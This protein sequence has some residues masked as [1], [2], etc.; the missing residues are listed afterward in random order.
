[1]NI[2][3]LIEKNPITRLSNDY[4][5]K[6]LEKIKQLAQPY[7]IKLKLIPDDGSGVPEET[8]KKFYAGAGFKSPSKDAY[9]MTWEPE[10]LDETTPEAMSRI[11]KLFQK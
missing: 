11:D 4:N 2:V 7:G 6:L 3:E 5:N 9:W 8:L 10:K 1:M